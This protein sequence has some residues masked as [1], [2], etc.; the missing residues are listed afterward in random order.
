[1][2]KGGGLINLLGRKTEQPEILTD[3]MIRNAIV[4]FYWLKLLKQIGLA[5]PK[6]KKIIIINFFKYFVIKISQK[7]A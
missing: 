6:A 2:C 3:M 7:R 4:L 5:R 1:M